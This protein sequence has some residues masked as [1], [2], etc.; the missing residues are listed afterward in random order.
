MS[1]HGLSSS[2]PT[3]NSFPV[4]NHTEKQKTEFF[5]FSLQ[6]NV[7]FVTSDSKKVEIKSK[8]ERSVGNVVMN[9]SKTLLRRETDDRMEQDLNG[10]CRSFVMDIS[11]R[12]EFEFYSPGH[13]PHQ[14]YPSQMDCVKTIVGKNST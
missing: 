12:N 11:V 14:P 4:P 3:D 13:T 6:R 7:S 5:K 9:N 2:R 8:I 10:P 1:D